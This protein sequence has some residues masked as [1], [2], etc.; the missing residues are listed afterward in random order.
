MS[1][2]DI[3]TDIKKKILQKQGYKSEIATTISRVSCVSIL[4]E[5]IKIEKLRI[6]LN[7]SNIEKMQIQMKKKQILKEIKESFKVEYLD[8]I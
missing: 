5:N 6:Y 7:I 1:L 3:F 8:I 2:Q 4:P